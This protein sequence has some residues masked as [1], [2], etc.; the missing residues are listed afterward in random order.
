MAAWR[1]AHP[2]LASPRDPSPREECGGECC[3]S[4]CLSAHPGRAALPPSPSSQ[5]CN[6]TRCK[7][8]T[9]HAWQLGR[10]RATS[11]TS[12]IP[13]PHQSSHIKLVILLYSISAFRKNTTSPN[14]TF[15]S[16]SCAHLALCGPSVAICGPL[17]ASVAMG[18]EANVCRMQDRKKERHTQSPWRCMCTNC[19]RPA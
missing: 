17:R 10:A 1:R 12:Y 15:N 13:Y 3:V 11:T 8:H 19:T 2:R 4:A 14:R 6:R 7:V 18:V 9:S 5:P 16:G